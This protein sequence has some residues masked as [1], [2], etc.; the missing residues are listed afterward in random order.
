[1]VYTFRKSSLPNEF[2]CAKMIATLKKSNFQSSKLRGLSLFKKS[3]VLKS[4]LFELCPKNH[5]YGGPSPP[6]LPLIRNK[7][8]Y[9]LF[10]MFPIVYDAFL[11]CMLYDQYSQYKYLYISHPNINCCNFPFSCKFKL[12]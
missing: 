2:K 5:Y 12:I 7:I 10:E 8:N 3:K 9:V 6:L 11:I 1:M 4:L